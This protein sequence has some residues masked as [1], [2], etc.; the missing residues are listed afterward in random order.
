MANGMG[1]FMHHGTGLGIET[2]ARRQG[3]ECRAEPGLHVPAGVDVGGG[4]IPGRVARVIRVDPAIGRQGVATVE[5][6]THPVE[7]C[8]HPLVAILAEGTEPGPVG[9]VLIAAKGRFIVVDLVVG[10]GRPGSSDG[11][12][13]A[14]RGTVSLGGTGT[15]KRH[16]DGERRLRQRTQAQ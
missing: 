11:H 2:H 15:V 8:T 4:D 12:G 3:K 13:I 1:Q 16:V 9:Q 10:I 5:L 14:H 7:H 6:E